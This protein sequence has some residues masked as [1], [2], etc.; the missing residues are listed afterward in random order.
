MQL[1]LVK[2]I[3][4]ILGVTI[5]SVFTEV[6]TSDFFWLILSASDH[7]QSHYHLRLNLA[8]L[9]N[10]HPVRPHCELTRPTESLNINIDQIIELPSLGLSC[11]APDR[12]RCPLS[13]QFRS[14]LAPACSAP[15]IFFLFFSLSYVC[16]RSCALRGS[17]PSRNK[18]TPR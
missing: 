10:Q 7:P 2:F 11:W 14:M 3:N 15:S 18:I 8:N 17:M 13:H 12:L 1:D 9:S 6:K 16:T 4:W 5:Y